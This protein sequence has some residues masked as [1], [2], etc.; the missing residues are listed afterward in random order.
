MPLPSPTLSPFLPAKPESLPFPKAAQQFAA[1]LKPGLYPGAADTWGHFLAATCPGKR[2][3]LCAHRGNSGDEL[4]HEGTHHLLRRLA[5]TLQP[6][7]EHADFLIWPGGN[8]SGW[9]VSFSDLERILRLVPGQVLI[10]PATFAGDFFAWRARLTALGPRLGAVFARDEESAAAL[11][12]LRQSAR[13]KWAT[14]LAPD[15]ALHCLGDPEWTRLAVTPS[16]AATL[17]ILRNDHEAAVPSPPGWFSHAPLRRIRE[18]PR[19]RFRRAA[20]TAFQTLYPD[21]ELF[22]C[23]TALANPAFNRQTIAI[24]RAL[25]TDRLHVSILGL[26]LG[27][28]VHY[29]DTNFGKIRKTLQWV[30]GDAFDQLLLPLDLSATPAAPPVRLT[31]SSPANVHENQ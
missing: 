1:A 26:L 6:S 4:I 13:Q 17:A 14:G 10:G 29:I 27:K 9:E 8:P 7:P 16:L 18:R 5:I 30:L 20:I 31:A 28:P 19:R 21:C 22:T 24:S 11:E 25:L 12:T 3:F 15:P 23:D 2:V